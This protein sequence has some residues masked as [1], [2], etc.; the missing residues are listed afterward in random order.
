VGLTLDRKELY[1]RIEAR[2]ED[3]FSSGLVE[4]ARRLWALGLPPDAPAVRTIGYQELF[5]YFQGKC[6]LEEAKQKI[7]AHTKAYARRQ[8]AFFRAEEGAYW[9][10]VTGRSPDEVG[11]EVLRLWFPS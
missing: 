5:D 2:V 6:T 3:M 4:E 7:V 10:D 8:L 1:R 9:I 11:E